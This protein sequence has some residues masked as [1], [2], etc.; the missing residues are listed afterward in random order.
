MGLRKVSSFV[1]F[2]WRV[3][4]LLYIHT[5]IITGKEKELYYLGRR[6]LDIN[7]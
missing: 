2:I 1:S 7:S 5:Y 6:E 3:E 4:V